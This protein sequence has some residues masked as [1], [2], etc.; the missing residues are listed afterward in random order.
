MVVD[1]CNGW[2]EGTVGE[3]EG[4]VWLGQGQD[5]HGDSNAQRVEV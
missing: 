2:P 1:L 3:L 4:V 5:E